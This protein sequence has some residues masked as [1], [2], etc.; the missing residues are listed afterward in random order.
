MALQIG[1]VDGLVYISE[2]KIKCFVNA[3]KSFSDGGVNYS[4]RNNVSI[5]TAFQRY[6][7]PVYNK[8]RDRYDFKDI[9]Q[10]VY[11]SKGAEQSPARVTYCKK[12]G[13]LNF[14]EENYTFNLTPIGNAVYK[15][16]ITISEYAFLLISLRHNP[17]LNILDNL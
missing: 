7:N 11:T 17:D 9:T 3:I 1:T 6:V 16:E 15:D 10:P 4:L 13:L 12:M 5:G 8:T 14:N 2:E